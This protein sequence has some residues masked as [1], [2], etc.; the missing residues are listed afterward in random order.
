M[1]T[2]TTETD[3]DRTQDSAR[4]PLSGF[5]VL[6]L[7]RMLAGPYCAALLADLGA[8]VIKIEMP[9]RGDDA[10]SIGPFRN[11]E[12]IY[13]DILNRRKKSVTLNFKSQSARQLFFHIVQH[14]DVV[15]E[16]FR[17]GVT[18]NLGIDY[19][20]VAAVNPRIVYASISGFGQSGP[21]AFYPA[22]DLIVQAASG[23]MSVT[24][25]PDGPPT[26][27]GESI[28]DLAA[29]VFAALAISTA[30]VDVG[31]TG[32]G[33]HLDVSMLE[34]LLALEVTIQ[35][36]YDASGV[37]PPRVGNR[38]PVSTP[39]GVY[40]AK[41]GFVVLAAA[42]NAIFERVAELIDRPEM[43]HDPEYATDELRTEHEPDIRRAIE[44][45]AANRTVTEVVAEAEHLGV[46]TS[47]I[48]DFADAVSSEHVR[49]R[50]AMSKFEHPAA[51]T[52]SY[53][54]QPV[55]FSGYRTLQPVPSPI[56]GNDTDEVLSALAGVS[57]EQLSELHREGAL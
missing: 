26:K 23:L 55:R 57:S 50:G 30:L 38:H 4:G 44:A 3:G 10:R 37:A 8:E 33:T 17:P 5:R 42:N 39:F 15:V 34:C 29:G 2:T 49:A 47:P 24:G 53:V 14:S 31:H 56:L 36:E 52:I 48:S 27:V 12:S 6:D 32:K 28:G 40:A 18:T 13:F 43:A 16:N 21:M 45:W 19:D 7:S 9:V 25:F 20:A 51:G 22:Y 1:A 41:D 46:P 54:G 11:G 35:S